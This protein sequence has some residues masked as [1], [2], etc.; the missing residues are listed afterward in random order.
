MKKIYLLIYILLVYFQSFG[1]IVSYPKYYYGDG[2]HMPFDKEFDLLIPYKE[3]KSLY[4]DYIYLYKHKGN[5]SF[6]ESI[7]KTNAPIVRLKASWELNKTGDTLYLKNEFRHD[8]SLN[9]YS[10]LKPS[11]TYSLIL[12]NEINEGSNNIIKALRKEYSDSNIILPNGYAYKAFE[13]EVYRQKEIN[14]IVTYKI[15]KENL[16]IPRNKDPEIPTYAFVEDFSKYIDF[17]KKDLLN[18]ENSLKE[19]K[20][21]DLNYQFTSNGNYIDSICIASLFHL[22]NENG[23]IP[24]S[25]RC[26]DTCKVSSLILSLNKINSININ[27]FIKGNAV[28]NNLDQNEN[29]INESKYDLRKLN[30]TKSIL[31]LHDI[32][33]LIIYFKTQIVT[34]QECKNQISCLDVITICL[35]NLLTELNKSSKRIHEIIKLTSNL[36]SIYVDSR[37]FID[38][39]IAGVNTYIYNFQSRN[40]MAITPVFGY[41][42]YGFQ[43]GFRGY[44][45]YLGFQINFQGL[46][47]DDPFN[48]IKRKTIWQRTCFTTAWTLTEIQEPNKRNDLFEKSSLITAFG[49]KFSH[50]L[51]LNGG[52][53]WFK[54]E[55]PNALVT[56]KS[57]VV[58]PVLSISLN[59]EIEKLLNGFTK[60][61]PIK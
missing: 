30:I 16:D 15:K 24:T 38:Y 20:Q 32:M 35:N 21:G 3:Q 26:V 23:C 48:Q 60:L 25:I 6:K 7:E 4:Y 50:V 17:F 27:S 42:Y 47:R 1:Q 52:V 39:D 51:M 12:F 59:L 43:K 5:K 54:N 14:K 31:E 28:L 29:H 11:K 61:I 45:P 56:S 18:L 58:S 49:F 19:N 55:N 37:L 33:N 53:L 2:T 36:N 10:L 46:N 13:K 40:D 44:T 22:L 41:A 34:T 8:K 9:K 57:I